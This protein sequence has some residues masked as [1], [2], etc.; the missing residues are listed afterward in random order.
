MTHLRQG[1]GV[2]SEAL[3]TKDEGTA[4]SRGKQ[5]A[6]KEKRVEIDNRHHTSHQGR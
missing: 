5:L 6:T 3:V 4:F 1:Y 2:A